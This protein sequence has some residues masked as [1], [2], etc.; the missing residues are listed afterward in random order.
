[1]QRALPYLAVAMVFSCGLSYGCGGATTAFTST[2]P[3]L[4][5]QPDTCEFSIVTASPTTPTTELGTIEIKYV[6]QTDWIYDEKV[7]KRKV[8]VQVCR[9]GGDIVRAHINDNGLYMSATVL[10]TKAAPVAAPVAAPAPAEPE[11]TAEVAAP[12]APPPAAT[13]QAAAKPE[14]KDDEAA[15]ATSGKKGSKKGASAKKDDDI[16]GKDGKIDIDSLL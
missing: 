10:T 11:A 8:R 3:T 7:F 9:A 1:M 13:T 5:A 14:K 6:K 4:P 2:G 16:H 15:K 12:V